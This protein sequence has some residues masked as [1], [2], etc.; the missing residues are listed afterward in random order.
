MHGVGQR[1]TSFFDWKCWEQTTEDLKTQSKG[2]EVFPWKRFHNI[3]DDDRRWCWH[4]TASKKTFLHAHSVSLKLLLASFPEIRWYVS[5]NTWTCSNNG[6]DISVNR[7]CVHNIKKLMLIQNTDLDLSDIEVC[8]QFIWDD[9]QCTLYVWDCAENIFR[10]RDMVNR[11]G[12]CKELKWT[13]S[14]DCNYEIVLWV[15]LQI[16]CVQRIEAD[17]SIWL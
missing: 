15:F 17:R 11:N 6:T 14:C 7:Q 8:T 9:V 10:E 3:V 1:S 4:Q 16:W 13:A 12:V 5:N 2:I